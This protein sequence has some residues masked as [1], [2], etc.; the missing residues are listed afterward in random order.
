LLGVETNSVFSD[1]KREPHGLY[2]E[3]VDEDT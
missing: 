2:G 3:C 1:S